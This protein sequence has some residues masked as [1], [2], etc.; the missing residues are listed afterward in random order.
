MTNQHRRQADSKPTSL[1]EAGVGEPNPGRYLEGSQEQNAYLNAYHAGGRAAMYLVGYELGAA[2]T[3]ARID[4]K[5]GLLNSLG[6]EEAYSVFQLGNVPTSILFVDLDHFSQINEQILHGPADRLLNVIGQ[7]IAG[8]L[9][10]NDVVG[11]H[12]GD[13]FVA[14]LPGTTSEDA[15]AIAERIGGSIAAISEIDGQAIRPTASTG[16]AEVQPDIPY[17]A[18]VDLADTAMYQAKQAGRN[19]VVILGQPDA[20]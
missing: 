7:F 6:L 12:G 1:F 5:T 19:T 8:H 11:R 15:F 18:A 9:R 2:E 4:N 16:I 3:K 13:E 14:L 20:A 10:E 17:H